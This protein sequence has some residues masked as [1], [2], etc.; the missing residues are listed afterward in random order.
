MPRLHD[1]GRLSVTEDPGS[2]APGTGGSW[3]K[4]WNSRAAR[5]GFSDDREKGRECG[6]DMV[7]AATRNG[8]AGRS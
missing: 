2:P 8:V 1:S 3:Q 7:L 6:I 4:R 5:H